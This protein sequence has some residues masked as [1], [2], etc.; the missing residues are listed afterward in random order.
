[1]DNLSLDDVTY[2]TTG[3]NGLVQSNFEKITT[4]I[5]EKLNHDNIVCMSNVVICFDND[6]VT[7]EGD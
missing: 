5:N 6:V 2:G 3:W 7:M 4:Y 1:M